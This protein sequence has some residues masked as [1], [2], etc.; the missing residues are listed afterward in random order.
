MNLTI[1][2]PSLVVLIGPSGSGKSTFARRHFKPTEVLSS[3]FFRGLI[4]DDE[5]DQSA[6]RDA[7]EVLHLVTARRLRGRRL[8]VVDATSLRSD[9]RKP[10][11]FL[12]REHRVPAV[13]VVFNLPEDVCQQRNQQR[14]GRQVEG[15][16][17]RLHATQLQQALAD[18]PREGF[19]E[20]H[21][22]SSP[23][24]VDA[25]V[26]ERLAPPGIY[27]PH[28]HGPF[29]II[30]DVHGCFDELHALLHRLGYTLLGLSEAPGRLGPVVVAPKGRKAVFVGDL[31]DRGPKTPAVLRLIMSMVEADAALCVAGNHDDKLLRKLK[32]REVRISNG[33]AE[34]LAQLDAEPPEF[35]ERVVAFL[36]GLGTHLVLD[37]GRLVVAHAGLREDLHGRDNARVRSFALFGDT[38]GAKDDYGLPVRRNW[39]ADYHGKAMVVYGHT[40][41]AEPRWHNHT[42]NLDTGCVFGGRLS[43]L[44]YPELEIVAVDALRKYCEPP[45]PFLPEAQAVEPGR[46]VE[47]SA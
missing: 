18:L 21:V 8:T 33:L 35:R 37:D 10:L 13:A 30:G 46:D 23:E 17:V 44:R 2:D 7:F 5:S 4:A 6:S 25:A 3:D 45:R 27:R 22:L 20:V 31:V 36:E 43:A 12:A 11:L 1:P 15:P 42:L 28:E 41:V 24:A 47:G 14:P 16:V 26:V 39:A 38:T 40:P 9:A 19:A 29:D 34:S 32:G